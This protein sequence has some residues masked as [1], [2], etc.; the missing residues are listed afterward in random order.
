MKPIPAETQA[1]INAKGITGTD[2][3]I[4]SSMFNTGSRFVFGFLI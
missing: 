4:F 1:S 3:N 2:C